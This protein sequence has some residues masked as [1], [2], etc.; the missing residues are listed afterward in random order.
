MA[1]KSS[2]VRQALK[3]VTET[4]ATPSTAPKNYAT[5]AFD[6]SIL[7]PPATIQIGRAGPGVPAM[8]QPRPAPQRTVVVPNRGAVPLRGGSV[9]VRQN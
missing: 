2:T 6:P 1:A 9:T 3:P 5:P 4:S 7:F 8:Q